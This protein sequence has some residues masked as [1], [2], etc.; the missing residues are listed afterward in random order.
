MEGGDNAKAFISTLRKNPEL[1]EV[2]DIQTYGFGRDLKMLNPDS[3][4]FSE[5]QTNISSAIRDLAKLG[6]KS[7][8]ALVVI[9]DG[10]QTV[11]EDYQYLKAGE[12][13]D[14]FTVVVGDTTAQTDLYINSLNVNKYAFL[15]NNF[16]VEIFVNY[17]GKETVN[18]NIIIRSGNGIL[19]SQ[20]LEFDQD[21]TS[22]VLNITLPANQ[23]GVKTY[24]VEISELENERNTVNNSRSFGVEVIDER[25]KVLILSAVSHPDLGMF[26]KSIEANEQRE[27]E[28]ALLKNFNISQLND[29]QIFIVYQPNN[30]FKEVFSEFQKRNSNF[31]VVSG[32]ETNWDFLNSTIPFSKDFISQPQDYLPVYNENYSAFQFEDI[33][34]S[35][36]PPLVDA[37]GTMNLNIGKFDPL[38]FQMVE[39]VP[40]TT[41]LLATYE[42]G[43]SKRAFLLGENIWKW[44][45]QSFVDNNNFEAFDNFFGKMVQYL[46]SSQKRDRLTVDVKNFFAENEEII[47]SAQFFDQNFQFN[48]GAQLNLTLVNTESNT[49]LEA[50]MLPDNN[51]YIFSADNLEAGEYNY[52]VREATSGI[53]RSGTF[54]V[55]EYN[56]EQQFSSANISKLRNLAFSVGSEVYFL[57]TPGQLISDLLED[58]RYPSLQKSHEKAVPLISWK[59]LL[60]LLIFS[61]SAEWFTRKYFGLI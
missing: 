40:S 42:E 59:I 39:G 43:T 8:A 28:I 18:S 31:L 55:L 11:G 56:V 4:T 5:N 21:K 25:T 44:R 1:Q 13:V 35:K 2:F 16:P 6:T 29:F 61:L 32:T 24:Q 49:K 26:K 57:D 54:T 36:F 38:L 3:I 17:S 45:A 52:T 15:N 33:G 10:N 27:A 9:T 23:L 46:A 41:P 50:Q 12:N 60:I 53:S 51:R 30:N 48:P 7:Q 58:N 14:L 47:V 37:F 20:A 34:F 19:F 22:H